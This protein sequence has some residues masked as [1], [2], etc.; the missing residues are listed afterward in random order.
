MSSQTNVSVQI[1][2]SVS[3]HPNA[4][5]LEIADVTGY[6]VVVPKGEFKEGDLCIYFPADTLIPETVGMSL[7]VAQYLKYAT[8]PG[9]VG[10]SPCR[11]GAA[12]LRGMP[13]YGFIIATSCSLVGKDL[14]EVYQAVRY[15]PPPAICQGQQQNEHLKFHRYTDIE[16]V[17]RFPN[18]IPEGTPVIYTEKIHGANCR[19]GVIEGEVVGGSHRTQ[20]AYSESSIYWRGYEYCK[21][22]LADMQEDGIDIIIFG[23]VFGP[24]VQDLH[25]DLK[26][27]DFRVFDIS[28]HGS[29]LPALLTFRLC[30]DYGIPTV[31]ILSIGPY[32]RATLEKLT[33][34][35]STL[36]SHIREGVVVKALEESEPRRI[37]KSVSVD[38]LSR[39]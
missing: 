18:L 33:D 34:G 21:Q 25:Y 22:L 35:K 39:D 23:E 32:S 38:Y 29:Y 28:I 14:S 6:T 3:P 10:P 13:S 15:D 20:R 36:A 11:V 8:Y 1:V 9:D 16:N 19:L 7:G 24:G 31:P 5:R 26:Q 2:A 37:L 27:S 17:Q 30:E 12:R 4:D